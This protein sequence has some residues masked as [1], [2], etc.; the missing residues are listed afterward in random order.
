MAEQLNLSRDELS[1]RQVAKK[2]DQQL[3]AIGLDKPADSVAKMEWMK[4]T[5]GEDGLKEILLG[6]DKVTGGITEKDI[7]RAAT[8]MYKSNPYEKIPGKP[9][10]TPT[11]AIAYYTDAV[12]KALGQS[13]GGSG[14]TR[15][16]NEE[17]QTVE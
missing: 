6:R 13:G 2:V 14:N 17:S 9:D 16:F 15:V 11:E 12:R 1:W 4:T 8:D 3:A 5:F 10:A 7:L